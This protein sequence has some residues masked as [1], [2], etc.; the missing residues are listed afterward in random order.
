MA[1]LNSNWLPVFMYFLSQVRITSKE[2]SGPIPIVPYDAQKR[3]LAEVLAGLGEDIHTFV[4]LKA[5]QLGI[6]TVLL[7][8]DIFWLYMHPGLQGA[9]VADTADNK[10]TFRQT[11]TEMLDSLPAGMKVKIKAH[12]RN[13]LI[14]A[15]GSR[16]MYLSAGKANNSSL[17]RSKALNFVHCTECSSWKDVKGLD[18]LR[19]A[20][21]TDNPNRLYIFESTALGFNMFF[22][23]YEEAKDSGVQR[24][25]FIGWW[26]KELYRIERFKKNSKGEFTSE[27]NTEFERWW[28]AEPE[29]TDEETRIAAEVLVE[30]G[31]H[32][33]EEQWAWFRREASNKST[34][35]LHSEFPSTERLAWQATGSPFF[36]LKKVTNDM[37]AI[38]ELR[39]TFDGYR[40]EL[41]AKFLAMK[42]H[43]ASTPAESELRVWENP[44]PGGKYV[45]AVDPAFG[46]DEDKDRSVISIWRCYADKLVQVA[47]YATPWPE[48]QQVAWVMAHLAG[49]YRDCV[50]NLEV[51]GPGHQVFHEL[52][53]LKQ[54]ILFGQLRELSTDLNPAWA[55][56]QARWFLYHRPDSMGPGYAYGWKTSAENKLNAMNR[57]RDAYNTEQLIVRSVGL[58]EEMTTLVQEGSQIHAAGRSKDDRVMAA[59]LAN[60]A[61]AEWVRTGMMANGDTYDKI[62]SRE[63]EQLK[64]SGPVID[65]IVP[66]WFRAKEA[67]ERAFELQRLLEM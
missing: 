24:A 40:Y 45:I 16:L 37:L 38:R 4:C 8:L 35:S 20:L 13:A 39:V 57:L 7:A 58:L 19:A 2:A 26:A 67:E 59:A 50:I 41:G 11:I 52:G 23:M 29:L 22:D 65:W 27:P 49:C 17:G 9:L 55:L 31:H 60:Y 64:T 28:A 36:N 5:R 51:T 48:T 56:D 10:E 14:L 53:Y 42:C 30:Y 6:S 44:K 43:Q 61:W 18:S 46:R 32:I 12:N 34:E 63:A 33:T 47:E 15:N 3:F 62:Q 66:N 1:A 21:A 54:Q 25:F